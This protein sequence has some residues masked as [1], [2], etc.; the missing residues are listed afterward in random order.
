MDFNTFREVLE[1]FADS[2]ADVEVGQGRLIAQVRDQLIEAKVLR[3]EGQLWVEEDGEGLSARK[4]IVRRL[5]RLDSLAERLSSRLAQEANFVVP[6]GSVLR[7]LD[8]APSEEEEHVTDAVDAL[9]S[10]LEKR[11]AGT[12]RIVYLTS[13]AGEGKSTLINELAHQ[14][15]AAYRRRE[16]DWL[17]VPIALSGQPFLRLDD[18]VVA[19]L[20]NRF[21]FPTLYFDSFIQLVRLGVI[22]PALD[23]FEEMFVEDVSGEAVSSLGNLV[24]ELD[25]EGTLLVAARRAYFEYRRLETQARLFDSMGEA[26]VSFSRLQLDRWS[27][28][29]F[30]E[31]GKKRNVGDPETIYEEFADA[32]EPGHPI[33]SRAVLVTRLFDLVEHTEDESQLLRQ[34]RESD[35]DF[36][37][38]LVNGI[39]HREASKWLDRG[40][41][42]AS[43]LLSVHEHHQLLADVA[44]EMWR[45]NTGQLSD[46]LMAL[47]AQIFSESHA[48]KPSEARQISQRIT[49][50]ALIAGV[51]GSTKQFRFDHEEFYYFFL[52]YALSRTL[53]DE[54]VPAAREILRRGALP[55]LA[56][57]TT[58]ESCRTEDDLRPV[59]DALQRACEGEP[60]ISFVRENTGA[61]M[62]RMLDGRHA[63]GQDGNRLTIEEVLFP[64]QSLSRCKLDHL[65]FEQCSFRQTELDS[66]FTDCVFVDCVFDAL[67]F[68]EDSEFVDCQMKDCK[69]TSVTPRQMNV[70]IYDPASIRAHLTQV[71][72]LLREEDDEVEVHEPDEQLVLLDRAL[73]AFMR[74]TEVNENV[75]RQKLGQ[76]ASPFFDEVL[77]PALDA[78]MFVEVPYRGAGRQRRF[79]LG[80]TF[81]EIQ[82]AVKTANGDFDVVL[83]QF[84]TQQP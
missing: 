65:R 5:A 22:I 61:L 10:L 62:I 44:A 55:D 46:E 71:G 19:T 57:E 51:A 15:A 41:E 21:R 31:Y 12:S 13:D 53:R 3:R 32:L 76:G 52:G 9:E 34:F 14:Q 23:G 25:G 40:G 1:S 38:T 35:E 11:W 73:R 20:V 83:K 27:R 42:A 43:P 81:S 6:A 45:S 7:D 26:A 50:H 63:A 33:L 24:R 39:L 4:W 56:V 29:N 8:D 66:Q 79:K 60:K 17:L 80:G 69:V 16:S 58:A 84:E 68:S 70:P 37:A 72:L 28:A 59:V 48:K 64:A 47:I 78:E 74:N 18:V 36:F 67:Y 77:P 54:D 49:Q 30:I 82:E 75:L 2:P